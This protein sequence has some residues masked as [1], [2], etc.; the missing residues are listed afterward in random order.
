MVQN[1]VV[2]CLQRMKIGHTSPY[3]LLL[4]KRFTSGSWQFLSGGPKPRAVWVSPHDI[5]ISRQ[6]MY[7]S[8]SI[9][10]QIENFGRLHDF[11]MIRC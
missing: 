4:K 8:S 9:P 11:S 3:V 7:D 1:Q 5:V 6:V 2:F 10:T